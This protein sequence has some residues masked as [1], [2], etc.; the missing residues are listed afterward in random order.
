LRGEGHLASTSLTSPS[1]AAT[2]LNRCMVVLTA[3]RLTS[4]QPRSRR[5][6]ARQYE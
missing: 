5:L 4:S 2:A 1:R 6:E 3:P